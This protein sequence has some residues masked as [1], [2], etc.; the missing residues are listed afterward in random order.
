MPIVFI[1]QTWINNPQL[2]P[3]AWKGNFQKEKNKAPLGS[4]IRISK[5]EKF[6]FLLKDEMHMS[7]TVLPKTVLLLCLYLQLKQDNQYL[8]NTYYLLSIIPQ[9]TTVSEIQISLG[10]RGCITRES[11]NFNDMLP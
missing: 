5:D 6:L 8:W 2:N 9:Q 3:F 11:F 1:T 7:I 4:H 10:E